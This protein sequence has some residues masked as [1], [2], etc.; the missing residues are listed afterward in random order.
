MFYQFS[1]FIMCCST[2]TQS[3]KYP[4]LISPEVKH[5]LNVFHLLRITQ[6]TVSGLLFRG[7][8]YCVNNS[9]CIFLELFPSAPNGNVT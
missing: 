9:R 6:E 7:V 3:Q 4:F 5:L 8:K 1:L 2:K